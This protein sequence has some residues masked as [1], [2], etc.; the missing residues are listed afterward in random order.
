MS[1]VTPLDESAWSALMARARGQ[2][3]Q[4]ALAA[5][6]QAALDAGDATASS[7]ERLQAW[8]LA[9]FCQFRLGQ[10]KA[11]LE[12]AQRALVL[13]G[14]AEQ[15]KLQAELLRWLTLGACEL[16]EFELAMSTAIRGAD[17]AQA[18]GQPGEIAVALN[19]MA[20]CFERMGD[21][22]QAERL[23]LE[24]LTHAEADGGAYPQI[25]TLNNLAAITI[26]AYYLLRDDVDPDEAGA[27]LARAAGY[28][29]RALSLFQAEGRADPFF[30]I[31]LEGN[32]GEAL[33]HQGQTETALPM[34]N[35][36]LAEA[37]AR[38]HVAQSWRIRCTLAEGHLR[39][40]QPAEARE[41]LQQLLG[42]AADDVP[43]A[44]RI[45]L[46]QT[47]YRA[48]RQLGRTDEA[49]A[50]HDQGDRLQRHRMAQQLR[51]Q[52]RLL[53]TRTETEHT[54]LQADR[55]RQEA[56]AERA[57]AVQM[58]LQASQDALTGLGNRRHL[59]EQLPGLLAQ[60]ASQARDLVLGLI[61]LDHFKQVNDR[62]GHRVGDQVLVQMAQ[63][64]RE[65]TR[66]DDVLARIGGEEFLVVL[67]DAGLATA[68][69]VFERLREGVA[70][71]DWTTLAPGLA[72]T[73]SIGLAQTP[74]C[75][76]SLLFDQA[77]RALY[78]AKQAGRNRV[79][80]G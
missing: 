52:S 61:D 6:M 32:L 23:M 44:T 63:I 70:R 18:T 36:S 51:A 37:E 64:L 38:G 8:H 56:Q 57:R 60:A 21:P 5:A 73:V 12:L 35:R 10:L 28:A 47:L 4:G 49:L 15:P 17:Q 7:H 29:R 33:L 2:R 55:A 3:D 66:A 34:L 41:L 67:P 39:Q 43:G 45:R 53:V 30:Q 62:H 69:E 80:A 16:G 76:A 26:G 9:C 78:R 1:A 68:I 14:A 75:D 20:A 77:D 59:D 72:V 24:A 31:F 50:H 65:N 71:H 42:E 48:C 46:H 13:D 58:A 54:R 74:P 22:W 25:T 19:A 27:A 11:L 40:G 79:R